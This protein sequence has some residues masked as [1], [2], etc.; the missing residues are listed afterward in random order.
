MPSLF[1]ADVWL[2]QMSWRPLTETGIVRD[3]AV[4]Q[5]FGRMAVHINTRKYYIL[6]T[7]CRHLAALGQVR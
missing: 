4:Y 1:D 2:L 5:D 7:E 3:F 6:L